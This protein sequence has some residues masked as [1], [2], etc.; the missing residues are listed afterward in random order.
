MIS[1][2]YSQHM[3]TLHINICH[4]VVSYVLSFFL[5][6]GLTVWDW[7]HFF[8]CKNDVNSV[9]SS[10]LNVNQTFTNQQ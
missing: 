5:L 4:L 10:T 8:F 1:H 3:I 2:V 7:L 9:R 6:K